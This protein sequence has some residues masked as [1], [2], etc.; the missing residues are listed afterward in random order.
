MIPFFESEESK[1]ALLIELESWMGVPW[2]HRSHTKGGC[3]CVGFVYGVYT[4]LG[5]TSRVEIPAY[6]RD[7]HIHRK[8]ELMK[9]VLAAMRNFIQIQDGEFKTGDLV[10]F[11]YGQASAHVGIVFERGFYHAPTNLYVMRSPI[12]DGSFQKRLQYIFRPVK[13]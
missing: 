4:A 6:Q 11:R 10:L 3:D 13:T 12:K 1:A 5:V 2:R 8:E 7:W 9:D